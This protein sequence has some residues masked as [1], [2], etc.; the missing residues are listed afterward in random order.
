MKNSFLF[1]LASLSF[2]FIPSLDAEAQSLTPRVNGFTIGRSNGISSQFLQI[3][4]S[5]SN[6]LIDIVTKNVTGNGS[7]ID[8]IV[9]DSSYEM[10]NDLRSFSVVQNKNTNNSG[11]S[12]TVINNSAFSGFNH[13]IFLD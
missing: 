11:E 7:G 5:E 6:V 1:L 8:R 3:S 2:L 13:S 9:P 4:R 10:I 12:E